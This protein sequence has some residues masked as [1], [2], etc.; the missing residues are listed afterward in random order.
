L[1]QSHLLFL[2]ITLHNCPLSLSPFNCITSCHL[3]FC[4][5]LI[6]LKIIRFVSTQ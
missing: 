6:G 1:F 2:A 5:I 3:H 4:R